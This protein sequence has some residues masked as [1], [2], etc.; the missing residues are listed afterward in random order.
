[1]LELITLTLGPV[2]TNSY[3]IADPQT[4]EAAVIDPAWDGHIILAEAQKRNWR[5][6]HLWYT[7]AH[8]DHIGGAAGV[9]D[10]CNL[11]RWS[12]FAAIRSVSNRSGRMPSN[13]VSHQCGDGLLVAAGL[14]QIGRGMAF[15]VGQCG[16]GL[17]FE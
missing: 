1:M 3:L 12:G 4:R 17:V 5:I 2:A 7:H 13:S 15:A 11:P 8:F 9:A 14:G 6:A 16:I 10:G